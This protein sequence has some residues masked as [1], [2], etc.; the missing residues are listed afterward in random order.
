MSHN[1][2]VYKNKEGGYIFI[3]H[4][5]LDIEKV[6]LIRNTLESE[7]FEPLCFYLKCLSDDDEVEGLIKR[8]IDSRDIF[9]YVES[10][11]SKESKWVQKER[12]YISGRKDKTIY[13]INLDD[14][15]DLKEEV[16]SI[17]QKSR[18]FLSYSHKD[19][20]LAEEIVAKL[21]KHDYQIKLPKDFL[22]GGVNF[23]EVL[24][25]RIRVACEDGCLLVLITQ[26]SLEAKHVLMELNYAF[27]I[28]EEIGTLD[29][30]LPVIVGDFNLSD[31][32]FQYFLNGLSAVHIGENPTDSE[33]EGIAEAIKYVFSKK[34]LYRN[35]LKWT[36]E[37]EYV[38]TSSIQRTFGISFPKAMSFFIRLQKD[39]II[40]TEQ[41][42]YGVKVLK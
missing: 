42:Q 24:Q 41:T 29:C 14:T 7:G 10:K 12:K 11:N 17:L 26:N 6:R 30:I 28:A 3:S 4:S 20:E 34:V 21:A 36:R 32:R 19:E 1:S 9:L 33:L 18:I 16:L 27:K 31:P 39:G 25:E 2:S 35:V 40:G 5:H 23:A 15:E 8:E 22:T 37:R 13:E 38:S